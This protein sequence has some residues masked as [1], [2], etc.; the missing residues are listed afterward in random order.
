LI[1]GR[2]ATLNGFLRPPPIPPPP[3]APAAATKCRFLC[4]AVS[5][6]KDWRSIR[7]LYTGEWELSANRDQTMFVVR[8]ARW[9]GPM[10]IP[11]QDATA[12]CRSWATPRCFSN[13]NIVFCRKV[14]ASRSHAGQEDHLNIDAP[15][16]TEIHSFN[17]SPGACARD[18]STGNP[19]AKC[20]S[21]THDW[22]KRKKEYTF[23]VLNR[24]PT[25]TSIPPV[26]ETRGDVS[27]PAHLRDQ[28]VVEYDATSKKSVLRGNYP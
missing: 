7:F 16:G 24:G 6:A 8:G 20:C 9:F 15:K 17:P 25:R 23:P 26:H 21:S 12:R 14:G 4:P 3:V 10:S 11:D 2:S 1:F 18:E 13:G 22:Q 19:A 27:S 28:K 5:P